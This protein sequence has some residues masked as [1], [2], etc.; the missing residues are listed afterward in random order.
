MGK[1]ENEQKKKNFIPSPF[2]PNPVKKIPKTQYQIQK[3][4]KHHSGFISC[5][6][7]TGE[8]ENEKTK[9]FISFPFL[10]NPVQKIPKKQYKNSKNEKT[11]FWLYFQPKRD[12]E[13]REWEK[14][15]F[16]LSPFLPNPVQKISKKNSIKIQKTKKHHSGIISSQSGMGKAENEKTKFHSE[17]APTQPGLKNFKKII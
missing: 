15:I 16:V 9:F 11:S 14:K 1:A 12:G 10:P 6:I 8:A 3:I 17:S 4:K 7:V 2:Q 5:Q 13:G